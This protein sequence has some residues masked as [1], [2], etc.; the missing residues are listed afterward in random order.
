MQSL[1][2][3]RNGADKENITFRL[4]R[5]TLSKLRNES[6][7]RGV[8]V[9]SIAQAIFAQHYD[10]AASA[11]QAGMIPIHKMMFSMML[12]KLGEDDIKKIGFL[13]AEVRV[14]D[15]TLILRRDYSLSAFLDV[16]GLW[17]KFSG[18]SFQKHT[19]HDSHAYTITHEMG[20]KWSLL[21]STI[22]RAVFEKMGVMQ[23]IFDSTDN[24]LM[25]RIPVVELR[26][27]I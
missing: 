6:E 15:M 17:M 8:S 23:A 12:D 1:F 11:T 20:A 9:N 2:L 14:K 24:L 27:K 13:F 4:D 16:L 19:S 7:E 3:L 18:I 26:T 21:L 5:E 25:F 10:W 22:L